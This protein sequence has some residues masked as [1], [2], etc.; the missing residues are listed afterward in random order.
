MNS[1]EYQDFLTNP[2]TYIEV[3]EL[4]ANEFK[5]IVEGKSETWVSNI[6]ANGD[7]MMDGNPIFSVFLPDTK[8]AI[9]IIQLSSTRRRSS[10]VAWTNTFEDKGIES[11]SRDTKIS[12]LVIAL[13]LSTATLRDTIILSKSFVENSGFAL[14]LRNFNNTYNLAF[15]K[16]QVTRLIRN[17]SLAVL[18]E[19]IS[20]IS[21]HVLDEKTPLYIEEL[22]NE[23]NK[24]T[25]EI[26][27][28]SYNE[29]HKVASLIGKSI[30]KIIVNLDP[31]IKIVDNR[32]VLENKNKT[33]S[34]SNTRKRSKTRIVK[35]FNEQRN[36]LKSQI[37]ILTQLSDEITLK[38]T[39]KRSTGRNKTIKRAIGRGRN[40]K[41]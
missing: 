41:K 3:Q 4:W 23:R 15:K 26:E 20:N 2:Q 33:A 27:R 9:R 5:S 19:K 18:A 29:A 32:F 31:S 37:N 35:S 21:L 25:R 34:V 30:D 13:K 16:A 12:E 7:D 28:I 11:N 38:Y 39:N 10:F 6:F 22:Y 17:K 40:P 14:L 24:F 1:R 36:S 8:Q